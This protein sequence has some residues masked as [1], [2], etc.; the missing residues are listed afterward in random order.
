MALKRKGEEREKVDKEEKFNRVCQ[1]CNASEFHIGM[2]KINDLYWC[3]ECGSIY[4]NDDR[5]SEESS[6]LSPRLFK[7][8]G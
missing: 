4:I 8:E 5:T 2:I 1:R 6:W 7:E 3:S